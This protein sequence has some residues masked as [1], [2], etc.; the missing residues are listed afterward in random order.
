LSYRI[1]YHTQQ[2]LALNGVAR[3]AEAAEALWMAVQG[4]EALRQR[5]SGERAGFFQVGAG[6]GYLRAY[7]GLVATLSE[8]HLHDEA[9][10]AVLQPHGPDSGA[11]AFYFA[12]SAKGRSLLESL[13]QAARQES[14]A[15]IPED[16]RR[17]EADLTS[18][19]A[20][21]DSQWEK[22]YQKSEDAWGEHQAKRE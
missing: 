13:T 8:S 11:A 7:R 22:A 10:P 20:A 19:L 1:Q 4:I 9:L 15:E 3:R 18:R 2:G 12:E 14:R 16:L 6:G 21:L 5:V 17:Q